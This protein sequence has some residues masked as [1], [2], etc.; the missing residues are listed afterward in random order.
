MSSGKDGIE[1]IQK[2]PKI[3]DFNIIGK[4]YKKNTF[5]RKV[6]ESFIMKYIRLTWNTHEKSV[7]LKLF[8]WYDVCLLHY[9]MSKI[10]KHVCGNALFENDFLTILK[11]N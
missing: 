11:R 8:N 6:Y 10:W 3:E 7:P 2:Y 4:S 9:I 1:K 5:K